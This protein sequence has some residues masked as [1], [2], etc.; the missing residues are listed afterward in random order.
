MCIINTYIRLL[1]CL[2]RV[3]CMPK[4]RKCLFNSLSHILK[5]Y[6]RDLISGKVQGIDYRE[7][8]QLVANDLIFLLL[9]ANNVE[10]FDDLDNVLDVV[11]QLQ[12]LEII[13]KK[14]MPTIDVNCIGILWNTLNYELMQEAIK[15][16]GERSEI[17]DYVAVDLQDE[18]IDFIYDIYRHNDEFEGIPYFKSCG[19][20]DKYD[21]NTIVVLNLIVRVSN[22]I[23]YNR[24]KGYL[25][26]EISDLKQ[27]IRK[28]FKN[29]IKNYGYDTVFHLTVDEEEYHYTDM[30]C[31][32]Y[33]RNYSDESNGK[34]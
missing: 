15:L 9:H 11:N 28:M 21:S 16:I 8:I 26:K 22:Y 6:M 4:L 33:I 5:T 18:Y 10:K 17:V 3:N 12:D 19:L 2:N 27:Y 23:Y 24:M 29:R 1:K 20:V 30:V 25:F 32:K 7:D 34:K 31:K 13:D 14:L